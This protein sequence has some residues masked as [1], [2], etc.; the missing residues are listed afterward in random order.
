MLKKLSILIVILVGAAMTLKAQNSGDVLRYSLEYPSYDPVSIV[1]PGI[2]DASGVGSFQSNPASL[3]L[4]DEGYFSFGL[5]NRFVSEDSKYLNNSSSFSDNE[6]GIGNLALAYK[7]PTDRGSLVIGGGY[8]Q[9]TDFNRALSGGGRNNSSTITD[10]YNSSMADDSLFFAAFDVYAVDFATTDSSYA[11]TKSILRFFSNPNDYPG[12]NQDFELTEEGKMGEYSAF[13]ATEF[14]EN[15]FLGFSIGYLSG[16]Y[17][18]H[19]DFLELDRDNDYSADFIDTSGD[20]NPQTDINAIKSTDIINADI[21]A[22]SARFGFVYKPI[23]QFSIGG[24]YEFPSV[25]SIDEEYNTKLETTFDNGVVFTD[26]APGRFSYKIKRP[27]RINGGVT[28]KS[29]NGLK[30]SA[31]AEAVFYSDAR[32]RLESLKNNPIENSINTTVESNAQNVVN[33]RGA[34]EYSFSDRFTPRAG[35]AYFPSPQKGLNRDRQFINAGFSAQVTEGLYFD[36]GAQY[37]F[38]KDENTL[39]ETPST[40]E[41]A[42]ED[43]NRI[44]VMAGFRMTL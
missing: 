5:S 36:L 3:A 10:F 4:L 2:S 20:G 41:T 26:E 42:T 9:T 44:H 33:L 22:F 29:G 15:I 24:S 17:S 19:R 13:L 40:S 37:S 31:A 18:Y 16:S 43:V 6:V 39:Y 21:K 32:I 30:F 35:Y 25:L 28:L 11:N 12:I 34:L 7:F 1:M 14:A 23:E 38:W 27:Q 8:S